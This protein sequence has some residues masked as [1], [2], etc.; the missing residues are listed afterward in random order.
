MW[1]EG[2]DAAQAGNLAK[3]IIA[4]YPVC[5]KTIPEVD[6]AIQNYLQTLR[7]FVAAKIQH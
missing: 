7:I 5:G 3:G 6:R 1:V 4:V 2:Q